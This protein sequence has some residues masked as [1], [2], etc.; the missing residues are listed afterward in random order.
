MYVYKWAAELYARSPTKCLQRSQRTPNPAGAGSHFLHLLRNSVSISSI[1]GGNYDKVQLRGGLL[2]YTK[3][4][5]WASWTD[6][7]N[8]SHLQPK[9][10]SPLVFWQEKSTWTGEVGRLVRAGWQVL[11]FLFLHHLLQWMR[12]PPFNTPPQRSH[13]YRWMQDIIQVLPHPP[14]PELWTDYYYNGKQEDIFLLLL[15]VSL[16]QFLLWSVHA[17]C[18]DSLTEQSTACPDIW[19]FCHTQSLQLFEGD[20]RASAQPGHKDISAPTEVYIC[21]F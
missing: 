16:L 9:E 18:H 3:A 6:L 11:L 14:L 8:A 5:S 20:S 10:R 12:N 17:W 1:E 4:Q 2:S 13:S 21:V 19:L 7:R 15:W